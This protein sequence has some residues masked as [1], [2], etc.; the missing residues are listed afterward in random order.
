MPRSIYSSSAACT[1]RPTLLAI[2]KA[3]L[4]PTSWCYDPGR[5]GD[6]LAEE[7]QKVEPHLDNGAGVLWVEFT[8]ND[9]GCSHGLDGIFG[10]KF[11]TALALRRG[12]GK[13]LMVKIPY[14]AGDD[15]VTIGSVEFKLV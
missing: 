8:A 12:L 9:K 2:A 1:A 15:R 11:C 13:K 4:M 6:G 14:V 7:I 5:L 3:L 10:S